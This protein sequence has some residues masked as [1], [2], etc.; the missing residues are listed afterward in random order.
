MADSVCKDNFRQCELKASKETA[1]I[2]DMTDM[3]AF[4]AFTATEAVIAPSV[5]GGRALA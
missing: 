5:G 1:S 3:P 2:E 4:S